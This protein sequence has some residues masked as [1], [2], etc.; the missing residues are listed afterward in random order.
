MNHRQLGT[1]DMYE[2]IEKICMVFAG[3]RHCSTVSRAP[4]GRE[5]NFCARLTKEMEM[6]ADFPLGKERD[7]QRMV[8]THEANDFSAISGFCCTID[9]KYGKTAPAGN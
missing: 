5:G 8:G 2:T 1:D 9:K 7:T 6:S 3:H 4:T